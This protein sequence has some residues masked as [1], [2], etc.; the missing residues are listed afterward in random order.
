MLWVG[1]TLFHTP[2]APEVQDVNLHWERRAKKKE[3]KK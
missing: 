2:F 3:K 1:L